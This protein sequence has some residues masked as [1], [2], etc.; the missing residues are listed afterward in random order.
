MGE[1]I[2]L[3]RESEVQSMLRPGISWYLPDGYFLIL[4]S[5]LHGP[6]CSSE[7]SR[8]IANPRSCSVPFPA[9]TTLPVPRN[10]RE[11]MA[12]SKAGTFWA[13][14]LKVEL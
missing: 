8:P 10:R 13:M 5:V 6:L 7:Y 14:M 11:V 4:T 3:A 9:P 1:N 2:F 12:R